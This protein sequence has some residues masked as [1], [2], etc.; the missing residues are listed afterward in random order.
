MTDT[1][2]KTDTDVDIR[3]GKEIFINPLK[4]R[5]KGTGIQNTLII[6]AQGTG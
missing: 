3:R 2:I 4:D 5:K 6:F 1:E